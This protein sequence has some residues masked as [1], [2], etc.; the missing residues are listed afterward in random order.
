[1]LKLFLLL[2]YLRR[3]RIIFLSIAAV[4]VSVSLLI[5]VS[6]LFTGFIEGVE[7]SAVELLGDVILAAP[8]GRPF[9]Q[10]PGLIDKLEEADF[11][12]AAA[13]TLRSP[14]LVRLSKGN[15]RFVTVMGVQPERQGRVTGFGDALIRQ[16]ELSTEPSF[17]VPGQEGVTGGYVGIGVVA[18]VDPNT[19]E[20]DYE[21]ILREQIGHRVIVTT[22]VVD[23]GDAQTAIKRKMMPFYIADVVFTGVHDFDTG[24]VYVPIAAL[25]EK[26]YPQVQGQIATTISIKLKPG[27]DLDLAVVKIRGLWQMFASETLDW[28]PG[29]ILDARVETTRDLQQ[30][31]VRELRKQ[32]SVLLLIFGVVSFSVVVLVFCIFYMIVRLKRRDIA[33][34]KSCG[35]SRLSVA[36]VFLWFGVTVGLIGACFGAVLGYVITRNINA[37]ERGISVIFGLKLWSSSVYLFDKIPNQV[38]WGWAVTFMVYAALAAALGALTPAVIAALTRPVDV[39]RYE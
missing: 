20:Y 1:M 23:D 7:N 18:E 27:T 5:V 21:A 25:Q 9:E 28:T 16:R 3:R 33:I 31:Y 11:I 37:I 6:S 2:K 19:D 35:A 24:F 10:F 22:G 14:G 12:E 39:L 38:D 15:V 17:D 29:D 13:A 34:V 32:M 4:A 26:L 36:W 8:S 30:I